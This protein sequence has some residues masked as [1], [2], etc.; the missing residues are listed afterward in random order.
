VVN[1]HM[2]EDHPQPKLVLLKPT[3]LAAQLG[4]SRAWLYEAAKT[5]RIPSIHIGGEHGPLRFVPED[6]Q[7]WIDDARAEWVPGRSAR[8]T[9]PPT[10]AMPHGA[11]TRP[12]V[13]R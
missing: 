8:P 3:A 9:W 4:V 12:R 13:R 5:G 10:D 7:R 6:I 11:R 2:H 1:N